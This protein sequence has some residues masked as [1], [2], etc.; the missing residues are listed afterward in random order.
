MSAMPSL[1]D[2]RDPDTVEEWVEQMNRN[3]QA[4]PL[5]LDVND[6]LRW[7]RDRGEALTVDEYNMAE[8]RVGRNQSPRLTYVSVVVRAAPGRRGLLR[9]PQRVVFG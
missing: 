2:H 8:T 6:L 3:A 9:G 4:V 1:N 7:F 5:I